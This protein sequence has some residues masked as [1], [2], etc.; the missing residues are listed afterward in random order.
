MVGGLTSSLQPIDTPKD[1]RIDIY[2]P[3]ENVT[4]PRGPVGVEQEGKSHSFAAPFVTIAAAGL[5]SKYTDPREIRDKLL[6]A[7]RN[8]GGYHLIDWQKI[9]QEAQ[10]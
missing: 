10:R 6:G 2:G 8:I 9:A 5:Y 4:Y 1:A 3:G 7:T